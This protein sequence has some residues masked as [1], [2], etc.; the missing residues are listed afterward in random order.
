MKAYRRDSQEGTR[1]NEALGVER[2]GRRGCSMKQT[3]SAG[4]ELVPPWGLGKAGL[5]G[6]AGGRGAP[7]ESEAQKDEGAALKHNL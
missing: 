5:G 1:K 7:L 2:K 3:D 6:G 4:P